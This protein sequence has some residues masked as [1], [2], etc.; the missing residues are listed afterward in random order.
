[1]ILSDLCDEDLRE[2]ALMKTRKGTATSEAKRAAQ[3]LRTRNITHGG[4]GVGPGKPITSSIDLD[5]DRSRK[6]FVELHGCTL[7]EYLER[8]KNRRIRK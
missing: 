2:V 7:T 1:M 5:L 4:F 6:T 8:E 3:I